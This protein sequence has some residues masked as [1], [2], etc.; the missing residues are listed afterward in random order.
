MKYLPVFFIIMSFYFP[1]YS[2]SQGVN[3]IHESLKKL[4][5]FIANKQE[6]DEK[7]DNRMQI[8]RDKLKDSSLS[9]DEQYG[10]TYLLFEEYST[11][12]Y[13]SMYTYAMQL[14][15][16]SRKME[17]R[18]KLI[19]SQVY[20]AYSHLWAGLFKD[21]YEYSMSIDTV[22][23]SVEIQADYL[24]FLLNLEYE[25]GL[26]A[27]GQRFFFESYENKMRNVVSKLEKLLPPDD[28]MLIEAKQ[29]ECFHSDKFRQAYEYLLARLENS[30]GISR[31]MAVKT[32]D[33]GFLNLEM[34]DTITAINYMVD[35]AIIDIQ[36]GSRQAPALR[37]LSETV[38][39]LGDLQ[40]AYEYMQL[41]M[42]NAKFFDSRYRMYESSITLPDIDK[43]LYELTKRQKD[44]LFVA[45]IAI[46]V[47]FIALSVSILFIL[48]Q[49]KRLKTSKI[50][51]EEQNQSLTAINQNIKEINKELF[52]ANNIKDTYLGQILSNNSTYITKIENLVQLIERKIK[53][54]Q[55]DDILNFISRNNYIRERKDMLNSFDK[56]FLK[57]FPNFIEK[58]NSLLKD[59]DKIVVH[60]DNKLTPELRIFALIRLGITKSDTIAE[61]LN[62]S[63]STVRNYKTKIR[64]ISIVP[65]ED[66]DKRLMEI[67]TQDFI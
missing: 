36:I 51:I 52:D 38:Y 58:F 12:K 42:N 64:N 16:L 34:G 45:I 67:E 55:Y 5:G 27:K 56:M 37:K 63:S 23:T 59:E 25:C 13:D 33:A 31:Q 49:N 43:D 4:D 57:L 20:L 61:I 17:D 35:A 19:K 14:M 32:G 53:V 39:A 29:K 1:V 30:Y 50:L 11:Y 22:G 54:K 26:Y 44:E 60:E 62:Y 48:K 2:N 10:F 24:L 21:A 7:K 15:D 18:D 66:F 8:L 3:P 6:Y 28:D 65:N 40:H 41:S 9:L 47:I 46:I